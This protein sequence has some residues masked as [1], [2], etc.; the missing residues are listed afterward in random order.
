MHM[1]VAHH[2][3]FLNNRWS[4]AKR[5]A[6]LWEGEGKKGAESGGQGRSVHAG[7]R[8]SNDGMVTP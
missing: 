8:E 3:I 2:D 6:A 7:R 4:A 1:Y 5:G